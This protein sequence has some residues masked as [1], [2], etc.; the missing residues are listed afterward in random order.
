MDPDP[1]GP[2]TY[3]SYGSGSATLFSCRF[4][5]SD[6]AVV[7]RDSQLMQD[8]GILGRDIQRLVEEPLS[9]VLVVR[10]AIL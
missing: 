7:G 6:L 10:Q 1:E 4:C 3:G 2:K 5:S 8:K 9:K